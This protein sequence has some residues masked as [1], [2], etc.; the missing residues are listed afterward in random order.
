MQ[1]ALWLRNALVGGRVQ[2]LRKWFVHPNCDN[3]V[4][5]LDHLAR[6]KD[7]TYPDV[8]RQI[9]RRALY[10]TTSHEIAGDLIKVP[11]LIDYDATS[12]YPTA[13]HRYPI[14]LN[15]GRAV[16]GSEIGMPADIFVDS[17]P[18]AIVMIDII[19]P[20]PAL[21]FT[22]NTTRINGRLLYNLDV[23]GNSIYNTVDL[24]QMIQ[25]GYDVGKV[26]MGMVFEE[27]STIL[28]SNMEDLFIKRLKAKVN[29]NV[30]VDLANKGT[31]KSTYGKLCEL[32]HDSTT[33]IFKYDR[34]I[35]IDRTGYRYYMTTGVPNPKSYTWVGPNNKLVMMQIDL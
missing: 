32:D 34:A 8:K 9:V 33:H 29:G 15:G 3:L 28:R 22:P 13:M 6:T 12:L 20:N 27:E 2:V 5:R 11:F 25:L 24:K 31:M 21:V 7:D 17:V 19:R 14:Y 4:H 10:E 35:E 30:S 26:K 1:N 18:F 23:T 16:S